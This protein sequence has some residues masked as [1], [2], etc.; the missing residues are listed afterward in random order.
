MIKRMFLSNLLL[1]FLI[2]ALFLIFGREE[3][4]AGCFPTA[5]IEAASLAALRSEVAI[6]KELQ[7]ASCAEADSSRKQ[8]YEEIQL[9]RLERILVPLSD[10]GGRELSKILVNEQEV[11]YIY[12]AESRSLI[13]VSVS[14]PDAC[15]AESV[16]ERYAAEYGGETE[17]SQYLYNRERGDILSIIDGCCVQICV[18]KDDACNSFSD[19]KNYFHFETVYF[20]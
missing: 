1:V 9:A 14:R 11:C 20:S 10:F 13:L 3:E 2:L 18:G 15:T 5:E 6:A 4:V 7:A 16:Y 17:M 19:L 12:S 8:V